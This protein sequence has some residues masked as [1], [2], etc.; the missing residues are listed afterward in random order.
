MSSGAPLKRSLNHK[1]SAPRDNHTDISNCLK[2]GTP[3]LIFFAA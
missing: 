2:E 3:F 1:T